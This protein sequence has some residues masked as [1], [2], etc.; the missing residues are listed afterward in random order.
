LGTGFGS[1]HAEAFRRDSRCQVAAVWSRSQ[2]H[3]EVAAARWGARPFTDFRELLAAGLCDALSIAT[4]PALQAEIG[5]AALGQG[6]PVHFEKPLAHSLGAAEQLAR[7]AAAK[8]VTTAMSFEFPELVV[9]RE[10]KRRLDA[11]EIGRPLHVSVRW[12]VETYANRI[13]MDVWKTRREEGGGAMNMFSSHI[14][15]YLEWLFGPMK[16]LFAK[17][18]R[19]PGDPRTGDTINFFALDGVDGMPIVASIATNVFGGGGH[20][21]EIFGETGTLRLQNSGADY[22]R[23]FLLQL[24]RRPDAELRTIASEEASVDIRKDEDGRVA[25][26]ARIV[27]RFVDSVTGGP[28]CSP[29]VRAGLRVQQLMAAAERSQALGRS[30]DLS[31]LAQESPQPQEGSPR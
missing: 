28:P 25:P 26:M 31:E 11:G 30:I 4:P 18:Q 5:V 8:A 27:C 9:W 24:A 29:D 23:G 22:T 1:I 2:A 14:L 16:R 21:V 13:R 20:V 19:S 15:H 7:L 10:A 17:I 6:L 12:H 3:A